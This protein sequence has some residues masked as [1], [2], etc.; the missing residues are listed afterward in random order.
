MSPEFTEFLQ[1]FSFGFLSMV[2]EGLPFILA[3]TIVSGFIDAYLPQSFL[4]RVL[5]KNAVRAVLIGGLLG[6]I[7]PVCE[8]AIVPV[9]RRLIQRGL[10]VSCALAYMLASPVV[11]PLVA[12]ST[13]I[14][15]PDKDPDATIVFFNEVMTLSR[16]SLGY[17]TAILVGLVAIR[18][19]ASRILRDRVLRSIGRPLPQGA[20]M[21]S[22]APGQGE[23]R[24][25]RSTALPSGP[26]IRPV[27]AMR[28]AMSDCLDTAMYFFIG[29]AITTLFNNEV[30]RESILPLAQNDWLAVP[31]LM[32]FA[33]VSSLC[34]T[35][36]A[37][38]A[39]SLATFSA[40]SK[41]AFLVFGPMV[42]I[43]L[44]FMYSAVFRIRFVWLLVTSLFLLVGALCLVWGQIPWTSAFPNSIP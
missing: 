32:F 11:N 40:A 20:A 15:F 19:P 24:D 13:W 18:L 33:F 14:A 44:V 43:K 9:I 10:P 12:A 41:L 5:P 37:F 26:D 38:V 31:G 16:L 22:A 25:H 17:L 35:S 39:A 30:P 29:C 3:G 2:L 4:D 8:C 34:S 23:S 42:D 1:S 28:T 7:L 27:L 6:L 36:D 21:P